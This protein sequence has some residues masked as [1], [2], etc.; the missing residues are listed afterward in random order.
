MVVFPLSSYFS[1]GYLLGFKVCCPAI[2]SLHLSN[3]QKPLMVFAGSALLSCIQESFRYCQN[4]IEETLWQND[5]SKLTNISTINLLRATNCKCILRMYV[6]GA[7]L[8]YSP[9]DP[10]KTK[11]S[12]YQWLQNNLEVIWCP[13]NLLFW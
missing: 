5:K 11:L 10:P 8:M 13:P 7:P 4:G 2:R 9:Y 1:L 12:R 3:L 6:W